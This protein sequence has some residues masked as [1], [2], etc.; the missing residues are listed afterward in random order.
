VGPGDLW[1]ASGDALDRAAGTYASYQWTVVAV[2]YVTQ[3]R[4][5]I[6][7]TNNAYRKNDRQMP[8]MTP[9]KTGNS[10]SAHT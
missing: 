10:S 4:T 9:V 3:L 8:Y 6:A 2:A 5:Q 1:Q 7:A